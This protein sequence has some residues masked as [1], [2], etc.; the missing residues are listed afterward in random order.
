MPYN[1]S[2]PGPGVYSIKAYA[3]LSNGAYVDSLYTGLTELKIEG[4][5]NVCSNIPLVLHFLCNKCCL[6]I[7]RN[8]NKSNH[9]STSRY[10]A[11]Y[12]TACDVTLICNIACNNRVD[13]LYCF[14]NV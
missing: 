10:D 1:D 6:V 9:V 14:I 11:F 7:I 4:R 8:T 12:D 2:L 3:V 13:L 5:L